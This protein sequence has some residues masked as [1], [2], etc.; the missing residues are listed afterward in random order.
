MN[1]AWRG[2]HGG[3][4]ETMAVMAIDPALVDRS[5]YDGMHLELG[6][7]GEE[8]TPVSFNENIYHGV[9][10]IVPRLATE[11]TDNGWRGPDD[12]KYADEAMGREMLD[13]CAAY[14][15]DFLEAFKKVDPKK[16]NQTL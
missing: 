6:A 7:L 5:A 3:G 8:F 2:G 10:I 11:A 16:K 9:K 15:C 14:I 12:P 4:E 13:T 1:D